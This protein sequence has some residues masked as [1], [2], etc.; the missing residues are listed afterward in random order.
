[1]HKSRGGGQHKA[2]QRQSGKQEGNS[3]R[4]VNGAIADYAWQPPRQF[5]TAAQIT[6]AD[7]ARDEDKK[8]S[9]HKRDG[10][11]RECCFTYPCRLHGIGHASA[12]A[13]G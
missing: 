3:F 12:G 9:E 8:D 6:L 2:V 10:R 4:L 11:H 13:K 7:D 1:M 5:C